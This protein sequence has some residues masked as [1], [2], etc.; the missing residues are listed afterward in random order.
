MKI[1]PLGKTGLGKSATGNTI[2]GGNEFVEEASSVSVTTRCKKKTQQRF[3]RCVSV[4]DTPGIFGT[5]FSND[6]VIGEIQKCMEMSAAGPHVFLL[7]IRLDR[8][9]E[10]EEKTVTWIKEN[11]G[12]DASLNTIILFTH[13]DQLKGKPVDAFIKESMKICKL[14]DGFGGR[15]HV[16][17]NTDKGNVS[18]VEE[19]LEKIYQ[20][21]RRNGE[22]L[23]TY[24]TFMSA[25]KNYKRIQ[26]KKELEEATRTYVGYFQKAGDVFFKFVEDRFTS[27]LDGIGLSSAIVGSG[28]LLISQALASFFFLGGFGILA[29][30][31]YQRRIRKRSNQK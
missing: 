28:A 30:K 20:L 3:G 9:T 6:H 17:N 8:F 12:D 16:F 31:L 21:V 10:E 2:L 15:Y 13:V 24:D 26:K 4:I 11:F 29:W 7:V 5:S 19:L 23:Y 25:R 18:Q 1:V 27:V 22:H 14:I